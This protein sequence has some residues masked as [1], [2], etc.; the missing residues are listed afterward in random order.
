[1]TKGQYKNP[2]YMIEYRENT[3]DRISAQRKAYQ[4]RPDIKARTRKQHKEYYTSERVKN[5]RDR[6]GIR[7]H[8]RQ[9]NRV[10]NRMYIETWLKVIPN[11]TNCECCGK[12]ILFNSGDKLKSIHFDHRDDK[13]DHIKQPIR[14]LQTHRCNEINIALWNEFAF[15]L[16]CHTCNAALPT[17]GRIEFLEKAMVYAKTR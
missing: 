6:P 9:Y 10:R 16:L 11:E 15:G 3:K 12:T 7:E 1:M 4:S 2:N 14:W 8:I 17:K 5:Y 13:A